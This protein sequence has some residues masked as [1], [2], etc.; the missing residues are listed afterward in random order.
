VLAG[1]IWETESDDEERSDDQQDQT[2]LPQ[3]QTHH[4]Q[5]QL[6]DQQQHIKGQGHLLSLKVDFADCERGRLDL[7][8]AGSYSRGDAFELSVRGLDCNPPV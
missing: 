1:P 3:S 4:P 7:D 8:L 2:N 5:N 6:A